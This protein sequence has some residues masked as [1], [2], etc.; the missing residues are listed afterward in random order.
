MTKKQLEEALGIPHTVRPLVNN[1]LNRRAKQLDIDN[2]LTLS[3]QELQ[4]KIHG[5][6]ANAGDTL[7]DAATLDR[8]LKALQSE[9]QDKK[10]YGRATMTMK[11]LKE[12]LAQHSN[13]ATIPFTFKE[14]RVK[15]KALGIKRRTIMTSP[16]LYEKILYYEQHPDEAPSAQPHVP[17]ITS[18]RNAAKNSGAPMQYSMTREELIAGT[19]KALA[20]RKAKKE[21]AEPVYVEEPDSDSEDEGTT[22]Q[23]T[24]AYE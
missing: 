20:D 13:T 17:T 4:D 24:Y 5:I 14:L 12:A 1:T 7:P 18:L 6:E 9:A 11:M 15:G 8:E 21:A 2:Y 16:E 22:V 19:E 23:S 10:I 3:T